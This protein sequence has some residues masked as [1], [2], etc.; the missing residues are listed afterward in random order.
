MLGS[1]AKILANIRKES[2]DYLGSGSVIPYHKSASALEDII[3][4]LANNMQGGLFFAENFTMLIYPAGASAWL[5]LDKNLP[6]V[7]PGTALRF[8][9]RRPLPQ[10]PKNIHGRAITRLINKDPK[11]Y[12][13][14]AAHIKKTPIQAEDKNVNIVFRDMFEI[15]FDRL[16]AQNG[17]Q[18]HPPTNI[19]FLCFIPQGCEK[20]EPDAAKRS[21]LRMRTSEEHD[22]FIKFLHANGA[23]EIYS[24][25]SYGSREIDNNGAWDYFCKN[26]KSGTIIVSLFSTM[27]YGQVL[28]NLVP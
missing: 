9:L 4:A 28:I 23:E 8:V 22:L 6:R 11:R 14:I 27:R 24:L 13:K 1:I 12:E 15:D 16:V 18:Q 5:F 7:R 2:S 10:P 21:D 20:Y 25:Q 17:P 26:V 19:F 3:E